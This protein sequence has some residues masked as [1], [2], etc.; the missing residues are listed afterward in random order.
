MTLHWLCCELFFDS[1]FISFSST[2]LC[3]F[4]FHFSRAADMVSLYCQ[5]RGL[6]G[7]GDI[8][9]WVIMSMFRL[10]SIL[11]GVGARYAMQMFSFI[12]L[13]FFSF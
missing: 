8:D 11:V 3:F 2:S 13:S 1:S 6:F 5:G 7:L 9:F 10:A 4:I 12:S